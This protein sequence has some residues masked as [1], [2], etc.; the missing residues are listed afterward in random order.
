MDMIINFGI[1]NNL[2]LLAKNKGIKVFIL[3]VSKGKYDL[4]VLLS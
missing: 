3:C 2:M 1:Q 4:L